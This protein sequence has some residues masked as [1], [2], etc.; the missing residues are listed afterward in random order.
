MHTLL[1]GFVGLQASANETQQNSNSSLSRALN[2][3]Q[4][5]PCCS[6]IWVHANYPLL[7]L[8][9]HDISIVCR[10]LILRLVHVGEPPRSIV[11][12]WLGV[13]VGEGS[14]LVCFPTDRALVRW[15]YPCALIEEPQDVISLLR[16]FPALKLE[17]Q[18]GSQ[19][20]KSGVLDPTRY[21]CCRCSF[22]ASLHLWRSL[23]CLAGS[24]GMGPLQRQIIGST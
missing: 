1:H 4:V 5:E 9:V 15:M 12:Q 13:G 3:L 6:G 11:F 7:Q 24:T 21:T 22:G 14:G 10:V 20:K 16:C 2:D 18:G 19:F 8:K 23:L 17:G